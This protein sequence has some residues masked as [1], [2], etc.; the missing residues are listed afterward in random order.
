MKTVLCWLLGLAAVGGLAFAGYHY[1]CPC[2]KK[3]CCPGK[4]C[5]AP[6]P[7]KPCECCDKCKDGCK[8]VPGN[9]CGECCCCDKSAPVCKPACCP[10]KK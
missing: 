4:C 10:S 5:P 2:A 8:C 3:D 1:L 9:N 6:A 7:A